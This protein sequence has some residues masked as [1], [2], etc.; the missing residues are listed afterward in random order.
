VNE[1]KAHAVQK[2]AEMTNA[3]VERAQRRIDLMV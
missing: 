3:A 1:V 2:T